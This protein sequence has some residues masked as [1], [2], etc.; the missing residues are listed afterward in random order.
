M[1]PIFSYLNL[2]FAKYVPVV[3]FTIL[4]FSPFWYYRW[5]IIV[6]MLHFINFWQIKG[7]NKAFFSPRK[8]FSK[9]TRTV[10]FFIQNDRNIYNY[11]LTWCMNAIEYNYSAGFCFLF[12]NWEM[13]VFTHFLRNPSW[14]LSSFQESRIHWAERW[15]IDLKILTLR[16]LVNY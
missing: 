13:G 1:R 15:W 4:F 3:T 10:A 16:Q 7:K 8:Q 6:R 14:R 5:I 2:R 11:N 9:E 12:I